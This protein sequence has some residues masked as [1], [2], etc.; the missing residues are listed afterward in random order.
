MH[1]EM[2]YEERERLI[3]FYKTAF[4]WVMEKEGEEMGNYVTASTTETDEKGRPKR[5]GAI[6]GGFFP[7]KPDWP[8]QIPAVVVAVNDIKKAMQRVTGAGG[9]ILGEPVEIPTVGMYVS[10]LDSEGNRVSLLQPNP[11]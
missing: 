4:G 6:N 9:K 1:F 5:P 11:M 8:S 2:P 3:K 10:F 7:K